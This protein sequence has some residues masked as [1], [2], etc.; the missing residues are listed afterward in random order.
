[1]NNSSRVARWQPVFAGRWLVSS[2]VRK[3]VV[4]LPDDLHS[5]I[6]EASKRYRRSM[7]SEIVTRLDHSLK[8]LPGTA[9]ETKVEPAFFQHLETTFRRD[10]SDQEDAMIRLFRRLSKRQ[11]EALVTLL[12]G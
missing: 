3:F 9:S 5:R 4:R 2:T 7:N 11:R 1:M 6:G 12:E 10:L 8:G